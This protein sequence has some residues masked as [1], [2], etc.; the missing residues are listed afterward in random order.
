MTAR[1][2][3]REKGI[4]MMAGATATLQKPFTIDQLHDKLDEVIGGPK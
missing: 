2:T 1:D 4:A 3:T